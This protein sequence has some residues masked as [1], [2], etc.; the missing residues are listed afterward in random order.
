[1]NPR[2]PLPLLV[3][4]P[5]GC[6]RAPETDGPQAG[7]TLLA[8]ALVLRQD[9]ER[10][11]LGAAVPLDVDLPLVAGEWDLAPRPQRQRFLTLRS[12]RWP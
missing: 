2:R 8:E 7:V 10:S 3:L 5:V 9:L 6:A 1:M 11:M 12:G 4:A